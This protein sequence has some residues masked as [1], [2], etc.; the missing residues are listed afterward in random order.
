LISIIT[1]AVAVNGGDKIT[2]TAKCI[3][4]TVTSSV[5]T[6]YNYPYEYEDFY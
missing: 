1:F 5:S 2:L 4:Q 3:D 6:D